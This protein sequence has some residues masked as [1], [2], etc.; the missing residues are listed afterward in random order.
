MKYV[1]DPYNHYDDPDDEYWDEPIETDQ[2]TS[3]PTL[4]PEPEKTPAIAISTPTTIDG[5]P[6]T[7]GPARN[8]YQKSA[9]IDM[10]LGQDGLP[11]TIRLRDTWKSS[12]DP[13]RYGQSIMDAYRYH[14]FELAAS[15]TESSILPAPT[16]PTLRKAAPIL[17]RTR[18]Y[19]EYTK[20]YS[21]IFSSNPTTI[22]GPGYNDYGQP[23][24]TVTATRSRLI[25]VAI[26]PSWA[27]DTAPWIVAED[28]VG[29]CNSI[30]ELSL[31]FDT[32]DIYDG[33]SDQS[34]AARL[35]R[36][37]K[38]LMEGEI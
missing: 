18:S 25:S 30:R 6:S 15:F 1:Q 24:V 31:Q 2:H 11:K 13:S 35:V 20:L 8:P 3:S 27:W 19:A 5:K 23:G 36:H 17:L 14:L 26:D 9:L 7:A 10:E 34:I 28:I 4:L 38:L 21:A 22:S 12:F 29:C 16:V 32:A 33:E 37:E